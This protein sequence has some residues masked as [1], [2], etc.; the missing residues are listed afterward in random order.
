MMEVIKIMATS[1]K[2][3]M[4][5]LLHSVPLAL[6]RPPPTQ[7]SAGDSWILTGKS[8]S[9]SCGVTAPFSWVLVHT[10]FCLCPSSVC[11]PVLCKFWQ[12]YGVVNGDLLLESL[13]HTY[14]CC[15]QSPCPCGN[16]LLTRTSIGDT[17]TVL[18]QSL[19]GLWVLVCTRFVWALWASLVRIRFDSKCKFA[20]PTI[21]WGFSALGCGVSPQSHSN[22]V[23]LPVQ[24]TKIDCNGWI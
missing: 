3:A 2:R 8:G 15:T 10:R 21:C 1:S 12:P 22:A 11:F 4:H 7:A 6:Q 13:C 16:P 17:N 9:V 20:S 23:Q 5:A 18:S 14:V 19:Q 24:R